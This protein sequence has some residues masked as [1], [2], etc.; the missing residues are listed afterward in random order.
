MS[1]WRLR[2]EQLWRKHRL[3]LRGL[4]R[5]ELP[6]WLAPGE[7]AAPGGD[8]PV[9]VFHDVEAA[10]FE[11]LLRFLRENEYR[12]LSA[13]ELAASRGRRSAERT[14]ALTFDDALRSAWTVAHPLLERYGFR[15][16]LFVVPTV[17]ADDE[18][19]GDRGGEAPAFCTWSELAAMHRA[20]T[21]DVQS[22][23]LS[24]HRIPV[25]GKV[26]DFVHL[27]LDLWV[28]NFDLPI[29][30]LDEG[31]ER[32]RR[33]GAPIFASAPRLSG[34]RAFVER[35]ELTRALVE[36]AAAAGPDF[37][38]TPS[39]RRELRSVLHR[40]PEAGRGALESEDETRAAM[41]R[42]IEDARDMLE[43]RLP[44]VTVRH[45]AY[46]WHVGGAP[47]DML[48]E[49]AGMR[50]VFYGP[51]LPDAASLAI[52]RIRRLPESYVVR[53][54]GRG[55]GSFVDFLR[56]RAGRAAWRPEVTP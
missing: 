56:E 11:A 43:A 46:P 26:L 54:P 12:T 22:H 24:H 35:P 4:A 44:G 32:R 51:S 41:R 47:A 55:R 9:F 42:E 31:T 33:A 38:A 18:A 13:D 6:R 21:M 28:G 15:A 1:G 30:V 10:A 25:S 3:E 14:V 16:I 17:V 23:S 29:S 7:T 27:G 53:L 45:L 34:R 39:W 49:E 5:G 37:F 19:A 40:W 36:H 52:P 20:G 2:V 48:A 50:S 8:V